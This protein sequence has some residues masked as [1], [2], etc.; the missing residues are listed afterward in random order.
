MP[1][2]HISSLINFRIEK[3]A[4]KVLLNAN[5]QLR[6][7]DYTS[8]NANKNAREIKAFKAFSLLL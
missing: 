8:M 4:W 3:V 1:S 7:L 5:V 2:G 6:S